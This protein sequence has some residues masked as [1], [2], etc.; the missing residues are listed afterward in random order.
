MAFMALMLGRLPEASA[1]VPS[2][3]PAD[4]GSIAALLR[5]SYE[6][7]SGPA[8]APRPWRRDSSLYMPGATFVAVREHDGRVEVTRLTA[9]EYRQTRFPR[10]EASGL[11]ETE[12]GRRIERFVHVAQVDTVAVTRRT[13]DG[14][15]DGRYVNYFQLYYD[16]RSWW[17]AGMVWDEDRPSA[18]IPTTWIGRWEEV[19]R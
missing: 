16:G 12:V 18:P 6:A 7:M 14:P 10:F 9:E 8:A 11:Y 17:I 1:Q 5:A 13:A 4:V 3:E 15:I 19:T 2:G